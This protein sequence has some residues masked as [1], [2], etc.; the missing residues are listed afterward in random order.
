MKWRLVEINEHSAAMN[1]AIDHAI[2]ESVANKRENPT[3]RFYRWKDN[4]VSI[5][6]YQNHRELNL[7]FCRK[8]GIDVVRRMTGGRAVF[9]DKNDFTYSVTAPLKFFNFSITKAY[10]DICYCIIDALN[11]LG[12]RAELRNRNDIVVK[13]KKISGNA[14]KMLDKG[15]YMQHG[16]I[17]YDINPELNSKIMNVAE[18]LFCERAVS[19][20]SLK[21]ASKIRVYN[22]L[23]DSFT[24]NK[25]F[26]TEPLSDWEMMRALELAE[27]V[28]SNIA[29][30]SNIIVK[31]KGACYVEGLD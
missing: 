10:N 29:L 18:G 15:V 13:G 22:A 6:A 4:S 23:K 31:N 2:Y 24:F 1:M 30:P 7:E 12:I 8:S 9:H 16:T 20:K 26:K 28:Y 19:I 5:G 14:A 3:I 25:N 21:R 11:S 27:K 17:V